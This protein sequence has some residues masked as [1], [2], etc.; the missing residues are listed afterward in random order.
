MGKRS[1]VEFIKE[2]L[3]DSTRELSDALECARNYLPSSKYYCRGVP[4]YESFRKTLD[5][6]SY[7]VYRIAW[8]MPE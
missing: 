1:I 8:D 3:I 5:E 6:C 7:E 4:S 2:E